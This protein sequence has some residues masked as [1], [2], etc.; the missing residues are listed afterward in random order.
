MIM[1][2]A[3]TVQLEARHDLVRIALWSLPVDELSVLSPQKLA[4]RVHLSRLGNFSIPTP[5][6]KAHA[7]VVAAL[8]CELEM[9][10]DL[11]SWALHVVAV[12]VFHLLPSSYLAC[13]L[14]VGALPANHLIVLSA[15]EHRLEVVALAP[16]EPERPQSCVARAPHLSRCNQKRK[17]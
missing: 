7:P 4:L 15:A 14:V 5:E 8:A 1:S 2:T 11:A 16:V 13:G 17:T 3:S 10:E 6:L 12:Q 9:S